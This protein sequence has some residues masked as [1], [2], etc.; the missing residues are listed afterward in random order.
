MRKVGNFFK[1]FIFGLGYPVLFFAMQ[2]IVGVVGSMA[3]G[4]GVGIQE[5][6]NPTGLSEVEL[7]ELVLQKTMDNVM[8]MNII[9]QLLTLLGIF[10]IIKVTQK[11]FFKGVNVGK[12]QKKNI[13]LTVLLA[14]SFNVAVVYVLNM[15][16]ESIL[17]D[18]QSSSQLLQEGP[19]AVRLISIVI[20]APIVE[21]II[22]R[23]LTLERFRR[24]MPLPLAVLLSSLIF[25]LF[26]GQELWI[27]YATV[28][29]L[30]FAMIT[31]YTKNITASILAHMIF[32]L[33][34]GFVPYPTFNTVAHVIIAV[35]GIAVGVACMVV[36]AKNNQTIDEPVIEETEVA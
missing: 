28:I 33:F 13:L 12:Q 32:N 16:P 29:G 3:I 6:M 7:G 35:L 26:H 14:L 5:G 31:V 24:V 1:H 20:L 9:A 21:E 23:G 17:A 15:L 22:F 4:F 8:L 19:I 30:V 18:Y 25:G 34:G 11:R 2:V 27:V 10:I 36:L